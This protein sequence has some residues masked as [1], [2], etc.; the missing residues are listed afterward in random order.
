MVSDPEFWPSITH[1]DLVNYLVYSPSP[2]CTMEK[3]RAYKALDS[4]IFFTDGWIREILVSTVNDKFVIRG[5]VS[6]PCIYPITIVLNFTLISYP[7]LMLPAGPRARLSS[8][9]MG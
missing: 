3:M 6:V 4:H 5:Q 9:S 2:L 8:C 7:Q 1:G